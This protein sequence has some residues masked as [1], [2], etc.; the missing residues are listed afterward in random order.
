MAQVVPAPLPLRPS[1]PF[2][3][4]P[5]PSHLPVFSTT[6]VHS[7]EILLR[8]KSVRCLWM[9]ICG[10]S[11]EMRRMLRPPFWEILSFPALSPSS[12]AVDGGKL[13]FGITTFLSCQCSCCSTVRLRFFNSPS[14]SMLLWLSLLLSC[15]CDSWLAEH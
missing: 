15:P 3:T 4:P 14:I 6:P 13:A 1:I 8:S 11:A 9:F 7:F 5:H 12:V 2:P 10:N